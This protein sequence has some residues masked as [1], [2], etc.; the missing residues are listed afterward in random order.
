[1]KKLAGLEVSKLPGPTF[2]K[3]MLL[4]AR[5]TSQLHVL[6]ELAKGSQIE[7]NEIFSE[8]NTLHSDGTSKKGHSYLTYDITTEEGKSLTLD[9]DLVHPEMQRCN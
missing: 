6:C 8:K 1:M 7:E 3:Y 4:E 5:T 2:A 9:L